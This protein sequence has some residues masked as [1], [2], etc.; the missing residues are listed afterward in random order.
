L[1][2]IPEME[3]FSTDNYPRGEICIR[4]LNVMRGYLKNEILTKESIDQ[5]GWLHT[6][7]VGELLPNGTMKVIDRVKNLFKLSQGEYVSPEKIEAVINMSHQSFV[8]GD[9]LE[10]STVAIIVPDFEV[11][12]LW[13][14]D[15]LELSNKSPEELCAN[16]TT[17]MK[18]VK[19]KSYEIPKSILLSAEPF[20]VDNNMLTPTFKLRRN[21]IIKKFGNELKGLYTKH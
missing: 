10:S 17:I 15:N 2:D 7:D 3:Y 18:G 16:V 21:P 8:F 1:V 12:G 4:G 5:E 20:S 13:S 14:K 9:S 19:S 6:G 11:I